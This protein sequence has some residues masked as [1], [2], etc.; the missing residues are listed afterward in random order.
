MDSIYLDKLLK[1]TKLIV[2]I[3]RDAD[4]DINKLEQVVSGVYN[5]PKDS[6]WSS[7]NG[8]HSWSHLDSPH[9]NPMHWNG[10]DFTPRLATIRIWRIPIL[11]GFSSCCP[12]C[13]L[14][15]SVL[16]PFSPRVPSRRGLSPRRPNCCLSTLWHPAY[17]ALELNRAI[18]TLQEEF[19]L[20]WDSSYFG[21]RAYEKSCWEVQYWTFRNLRI[22]CQ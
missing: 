19:I 9:C 5:L 17:G 8:Q 22:Y 14:P 21:T 13:C 2:S 7:A 16:T 4:I 1:D 11:W 6:S 20:W 18:S 15:W 10:E 12:S 3:E